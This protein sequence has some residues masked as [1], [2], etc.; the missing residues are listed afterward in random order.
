MRPTLA[1][2]V[3][4]LIAAV[5]A[6]AQD[7]EPTPVIPVTTDSS[8]AVA[9]RDIFDVLSEIL[10]GPRVEPRIESKDEQGLHWVILPTFSYNPVYE[11]AIGASASGAGRIGGSPRISRISLSGN[12]ATIGQIQALTQGDL[13]SRS[14]SY[15][16]RVDAR[17][18]DTTR[19]TF[20]LGP[21]E[22]GHEEFPVEYK[23]IRG[24]ATLNRHVQNE[25]YAG[26]GVHLDSFTDIFD[27]RAAD[28][29]STPYVTY[30]GGNPTDA[31]SAGISVNLLAD[32]RDN[33]VNPRAGYYIG[34]SFRANITELG[35]D[36]NWQ[37][38]WTELR[39]Y[40][41]VPRDSR[42][43]LAFWIWTWFTFGEP[44][45]LNLPSV[46]GDTYGR[47]G[48]GYLQ[49]RIRAR[50]VAYIETEYRR[51]LRDDGLLGMVGFLNLTS[52]SVGGT[53]VLG[54]MDPG[55]GAGLRIKFSKQSDTNLAIDLGWGEDDSFGV[56]I[57]TT[58]VF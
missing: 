10:H 12:W 45:F 51:E 55:G 32:A 40:P 46:G 16:L 8:T 11:F 20:A 58:E 53:G 30:S 57:G 6:R 22:A 35:S 9:Q 13:Y 48:R 38:M 3:F 18:L 54:K 14:G 15:F 1:A 5:S 29:E 26:L 37:E 56:F 27:Q 23:L 24:Y 41:H 47:S 50:N 28:G 25:V 21:V 17:Y 34:S 33:P 52:A 43:R 4:L 42:N 7:T 2:F 31:R 49:G 36:T 19:P 39:V 44:P